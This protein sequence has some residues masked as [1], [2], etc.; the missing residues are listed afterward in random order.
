MC[1]VN[2]T[3]AATASLAALLTEI[4]DALA[5]QS[6]VDAAEVLIG[7]VDLGGTP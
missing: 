4:R 3:E 2:V 5:D 7:P 6:G 1:T